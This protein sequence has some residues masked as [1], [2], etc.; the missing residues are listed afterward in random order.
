[1]AYRGKEFQVPEQRSVRRNER[2]GVRVLDTGCSAG[3]TQAAT[4]SLATA[5]AMASATLMPSTAAEKM[6]PA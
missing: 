1:M 2:H 5:R 4:S 6:P 3:V